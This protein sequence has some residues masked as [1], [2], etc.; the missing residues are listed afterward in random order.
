MERLL[1]MKKKRKEDKGMRLI[2]STTDQRNTG[3]TDIQE[4]QDQID[5]G[6]G[7]DNP[8]SQEPPPT[9]GSNI[10]QVVIRGNFNSKWAF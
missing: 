6:Q 5:Q 4:V 8:D 9:F 1:M 2:G 3:P 7:Q 10:G